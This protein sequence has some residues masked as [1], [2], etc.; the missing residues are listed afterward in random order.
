[1]NKGQ[2]VCW[3]GEVDG[4]LQQAEKAAGDLNTNINPTECEWGTHNEPQDTLGF[5]PAIIN[6]HKNPRILVLLLSSS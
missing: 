6:P 3:V 5:S 1:M 4:R 2:P